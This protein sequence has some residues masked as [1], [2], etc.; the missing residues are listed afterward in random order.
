MIIEVVIMII[1]DIDG[2][3][4]FKAIESTNA[5]TATEQTN[6]ISLINQTP[7]LLCQIMY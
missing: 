1:K 4:F 7:I 3:V 5:T 6:N 2:W